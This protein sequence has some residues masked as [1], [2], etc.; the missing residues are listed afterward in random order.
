MFCAKAKFKIRKKHNIS[1]MDSSNRNLKTDV[2]IS[3]ENG[4]NSPVS[5][6]PTSN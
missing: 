4:M 2:F 3:T 5:E 6:G 1:V